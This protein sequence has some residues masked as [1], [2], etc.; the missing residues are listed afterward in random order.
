MRSLSQ[1]KRTT[2]SIIE[3]DFV[4]LDRAPS[5]VFWLGPLQINAR[6]I[7]GNHYWCKLSARSSAALEYCLRRKC[8]SSV[9]VESEHLETIGFSNGHSCG[10]KMLL[11]W[12]VLS[13]VDLFDFITLLV[14]YEKLVPC[15]W[16]TVCRLLPSHIDGGLC[17]KGLDFVWRQRS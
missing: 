6:L 17:G 15:N 9:E 13:V 14:Y 4:G 16:L 12:I 3:I 1:N 2:L 8:S 7:Y 5:I 11:V 10:I